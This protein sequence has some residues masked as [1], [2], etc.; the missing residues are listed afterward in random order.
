MLFKCWWSCSSNFDE[1]LQTYNASSFNRCKVSYCHK[2]DMKK[3]VK[4]VLPNLCNA[5]LWGATVVTWIM[6]AYCV[7]IS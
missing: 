2:A 5:G 4:G 1:P 6:H 7:C 3:G